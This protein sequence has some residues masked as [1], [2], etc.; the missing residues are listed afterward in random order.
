MSAMSSPMKN[1]KKVEQEI[2]RIH[3]LLDE[4]ARTD[5]ALRELG[6][7][8]STIPEFSVECYQLRERSAAKRAT[9]DLW[10]ALSKWRQSYRWTPTVKP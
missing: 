4:M 8:L 5:K 1:S 2:N 10:R 9:L 7:K 6:E 3:L